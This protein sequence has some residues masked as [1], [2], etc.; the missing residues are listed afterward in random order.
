MWHVNLLALEYTQAFESII[1]VP[2]VINQSQILES[3]APALLTSFIVMSSLA[4]R[5]YG[6]VGCTAMARM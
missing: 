3:S 1:K 2:L 6:C 5:M 4:V